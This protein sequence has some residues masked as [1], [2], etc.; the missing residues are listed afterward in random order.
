VIYLCDEC[1]CEIPPGRAGRKCKQCREDA[2]REPPA[3]CEGCGACCRE[4]HSPPG[5]ASFA[6]PAADYWI[7]NADPEDEDWQIF[8]AIPEPIKQE[9]REFYAE[10]FI[11]E[12]DP[13]DACFWYDA[14]KKQCKHY[15]HRPTICREFEIGE[16]A[17][18]RWRRLY[19]IT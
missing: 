3:S 18:H 7:A 14:E 1:Y 11:K 9:L 16:P 15:E 8:Q 2:Q 5:W 6:G 19:Q 4:M 17:C 10:D 12:G 13:H